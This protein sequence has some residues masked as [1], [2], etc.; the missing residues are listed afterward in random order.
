MLSPGFK[1]HSASQIISRNHLKSTASPYVRR[2]LQLARRCKTA[3]ALGLD[4]ALSQCGVSVT[5][6]ILEVGSGLGVL[7]NFLRASSNYSNITLIQSDKSPG[8]GFMEVD[9]NEYSKY[10]LEFEVVVGLNVF[11]TFGHKSLER[12][13]GQLA[14]SSAQKVVHIQEL[15]TPTDYVPQCLGA[16]DDGDIIRFAFEESSGFFFF[17]F[18]ETFYGVPY[19]TGWLIITREVWEQKV[20]PFIMEHAESHANGELIKDLDY[21]I[22]CHMWDQIK[23]L[24]YAN[25]AYAFQLRDW[26]YKILAEFGQHVQVERNSDLFVRYF[27]EAMLSAGFDE[28]NCFSVIANPKGLP[29]I[30]HQGLFCDVVNL[31]KV[32]NPPKEVGVTFLVCYAGR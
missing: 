3:I 16:V 32:E 8:T 22:D 20:K 2:R 7:A 5:D 12:I 30:F 25:Q 17:P 13:A 11:H 24:F 29:V 26:G 27:R 21:M 4:V 23:E 31:Q 9:L 1:P 14:K 6:K 28:F 10:K 19:L 18:G 15:A